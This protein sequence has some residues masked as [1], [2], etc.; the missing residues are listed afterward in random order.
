[1]EREKYRQQRQHTQDN[2]TRNLR[3]GVHDAL[4]SLRVYKA[5][6]EPSLTLKKL[7][8]SSPSQFNPELVQG[9][10]KCLSIYPVGSL[11]ELDSGRVG[12]VIERGQE[13][14]RPLLRIIYH[15]RRQADLR[16][17]DLD[18]ARETAD[19]INRVRSPADFGIN[20]SLFV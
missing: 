19:R 10:I 20:L 3:V 18:L 16:V 12:V 11:V 4:T 2:P 5:A 15:A 6:W 1:V 17:H 7:L 8:E 14:L 9:F 13:M